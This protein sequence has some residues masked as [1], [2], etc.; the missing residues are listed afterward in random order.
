MPKL[1][2]R[3]RG[4]EH[5]ISESLNQEAEEMAQLVKCSQRKL[6]DLNLTPRACANLRLETQERLWKF[7]LPPPHT[8]AHTHTLHIQA[9]TKT[10]QFK[11]QPIQRVVPAA[12]EPGCRAS[13]S[14]QLVPVATSLQAQ[15]F[16]QPLSGPG[17]LPQA[18]LL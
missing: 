13:Q 6:K 5:S 1:R 7:D 9:Q 8:L 3:V 11:S 17:G 14:A 16:Q 4:I 15:A 12:A 2:L 18:F 10:S